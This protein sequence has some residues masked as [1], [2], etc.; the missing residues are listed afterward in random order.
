LIS[1]G[2]E[3]TSAVPIDAVVR[4]EGKDY[5]FMVDENPEEEPKE[6]KKGEVAEEKT[7]FKKV[8]VTT[9]VSELGYIQITPL[10]KLPENTKVVTKG[11][12]YLQS[13]SAGGS[14]H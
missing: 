1:V 7:H 8:E 12:F 6:A 3:L 4:S 14:E 10:E 5:I 13:K 2:T 9:G 11:A